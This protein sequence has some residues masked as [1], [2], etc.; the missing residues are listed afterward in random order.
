MPAAFETTSRWCSI[1]LSDVEFE[2]LS[3]PD[4]HGEECPEW[5][6]LRCSTAVVVAFSADSP[7]HA[8]HVA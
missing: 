7:E 6:C 3:C 1:C 8:V 4:G 2:Q 5:V